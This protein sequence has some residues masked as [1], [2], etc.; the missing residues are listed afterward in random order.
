[1]QLSFVSSSFSEIPSGSFLWEEDGGRGLK[2][3]DQV[4]SLFSLIKEKEKKT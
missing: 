2:C 3:Q 4:Y 1:M